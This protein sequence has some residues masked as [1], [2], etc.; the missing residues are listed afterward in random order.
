MLSLP[1]WVAALAVAAEAQEVYITKTGT[2]ARPQCT[3]TLA[4]P[5]FHFQP[6][7]YTLKETVR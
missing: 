1:V 5:S 3:G 6:F 7:S 4:S 2:S